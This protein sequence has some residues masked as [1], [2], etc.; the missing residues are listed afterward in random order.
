MG[1][2]LQFGDGRRRDALIL[3]LRD[4]LA[5]TGSV[6]Q[7]L[8]EV[9]VSMEE[10]RK[11]ARAT[12]RELGRPVQTLAGADAVH[13]VLTDWP[14]DD[15]ERAIHMEA[16][17]AAMHGATL[18]VESRKPGRSIEETG[19]TVCDSFGLVEVSSR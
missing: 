13:A 19:S 18:G 16:L 14:R 2:V 9:T 10:W 4:E 11:A 12:G 3:W 8:G 7:R 5:A 17:K 15:R 1:E 6:S